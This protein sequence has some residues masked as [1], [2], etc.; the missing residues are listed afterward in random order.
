[1]T[2]PAGFA[3]PIPAAF[4]DSEAVPCCDCGVEPLGIW[5]RQT[6]QQ[7]QSKGISRTLVAA[8]HDENAVAAIQP[9]FLAQQG[10]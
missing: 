4:S 3:C 7:H 2:A 5:L 10:R 8:P 6:A 1:M 9:Q